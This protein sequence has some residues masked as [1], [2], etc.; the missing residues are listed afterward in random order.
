MCLKNN[1]KSNKLNVNSSKPFWAHFSNE[2]TLDRLIKCIPSPRG[3]KPK[4]PGRLQQE[5][6][7][8]FMC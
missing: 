2:H 3:S 1:V 5:H 4:S 7:R 8:K 6:K